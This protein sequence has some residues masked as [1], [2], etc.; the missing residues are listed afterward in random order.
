MYCLIT[1][2]TNTN[3]S[4]SGLMANTTYNFTVEAFD[5]ANKDAH[6]LI[7]GSRSLSLEYKSSKNRGGG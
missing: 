1:T 4:V 5:A 3:Y 7:N 6:N 2:T